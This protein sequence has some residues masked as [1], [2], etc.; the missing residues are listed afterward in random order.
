MGSH[1]RGRRRD[2]PRRRGRRRGSRLSHP[3]AR[4][5]RLRQGH[6]E[7]L[8]QAD[9]RRRPLPAPG[10]RVAGARS[11][12]RARHPAPQRASSG[13]RRPVRGAELRLVGVAVLRHRTSPLRPAGGQGRIRRLAAPVQGGDA[14]APADDRDR[15]TARRRPLLRRP[16]RRRAAR[17]LPGDDGDGSRRRDAQPHGGDR[18]GEGGRHRA[19]RRGARRRERPGPG[20][21]RKGGGQRHR[22]LDRHAADGS[23]TRR[24]PRS[25]VPA[26]ACTSCS[27]GAS[28]RA[29]RPSWCRTPTTGACCSRSRGTS[30][31]WWGPPTRRSPRRRSSRVRCGRSSSS[32]WCTPRAT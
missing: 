18:A 15:G 28:I 19:R 5:E 11:A 30:A 1:R 4:A 16:V 20:A 22:R 31:W 25:S 13:A 14:R 7:P 23:T 26:R 10:Q 27:T 6:L 2:R 3:A 32:C 12:A 24:R 29:M 8:D 9:S 21:A 17:H